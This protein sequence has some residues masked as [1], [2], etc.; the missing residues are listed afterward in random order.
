MPNNY[1][2]SLKVSLAPQHQGLY[3]QLIRDLYHDPNY[4]RNLAHNLPFS[5]ESLG[6][7][8]IV[9]IF[10]STWL[11]AAAREWLLMDVILFTMPL[12]TIQQMTQWVLAIYQN[13]ASTPVPVR[14]KPPE[15]IVISN[16][17]DHLASKGLFDEI[18]A[19]DDPFT[20]QTFSNQVKD[21]VA[22]MEQSVNEIRT[23]V[24]SPRFHHPTWIG[25]GLDTCSSLLMQ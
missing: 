18:K 17:F 13:I 3:G 4:S 15:T 19:V 8:R 23:K 9:L 25:N 22:A 2:A 5:L 20:V 1:S 6:K 10:D 11:P 12:S 7:V 21:F 14:F 24:G 16:L